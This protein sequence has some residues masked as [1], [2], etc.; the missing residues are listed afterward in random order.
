[1]FVAQRHGGVSSLAG[2]AK[3]LRSVDTDSIGYSRCQ[4]T[5]SCCRTIC[6]SWKFCVLT[7]ILTLVAL[8][9]DDFRQA[10]TSKDFDIV[11]NVITLFCILVFS[12]EVV[13]ASLG[14]EEYFLGF[15]FFLD[16]GATVTLLFDLTWVGDALFCSGLAGGALRASR[17]GRAGARASR[18]VRII[19][20]MRLVRLYRNYKTAM[21]I[22]RERRSRV[23]I[24]MENMLEP[25]ED[26][27]DD[28]ESEDQDEVGE[29]SQD[30]NAFRSWQLDASGRLGTASQSPADASTPRQETRVGKK[31]SDMTTRRVIVLVLVMLLVMPYFSPNSL[32]MEEFRSSGSYGSELVY[33]RWRSWCDLPGS[34][35]N[36]TQP[37]WC[38]DA[39]AINEMEGKVA[40]Q[41]ARLLLE[42]SLLAFTYSHHKGDFAWRLCWLGLR[43]DSLVESTGSSDH[44]AV[45]LSRLAALNQERMLG[46]GIAVAAGD[47]PGVWDLRFAG[48]NK[49]WRSNMQPL[50]AAVAERL[51]QPWP[52][53][54]LGFT[55]VWVQD[56]D[57][58]DDDNDASKTAASRGHCSIDELLRCSERIFIEP[59]TSTEEESRYLSL[60]FTFDIRA[61]KQLEAGL[62]ILQ[63]IFIC[64]TVGLGAMSFSKDANELLLNPIERMIAKMETIKD[65]PLEAMRLGDMEYRR[66][67][68]EHANHREQLAGM[69]KFWRLIYRYRYLKKT[70]EPMETAMLEKTIIKLG[71]LLALGFGEAGAEI[72]GQNMNGS[73][74]AGV[75][76]MV[77]GVSVNAILGFCNIRHFTDATEVLREK[78][79]MFVNQVGEIVHGCVD[80]YHGAPNKNIGSAFLIV[81]RLAALDDAESQR[82]LA[83]MALMAFAKIV[84]E[85]NKS[86]VLAVYREHP[87]L[88]Q[89]V[90]NFRVQMG[91]GL[92]CG[93]AIEG[94]IGSEFKIDASYLSPNVNVAT[95]LEAAAGQFSVW[96]L[97]S[98]FIVELYNSEMASKCRLIDHVTVKGSRIPL[99]LYTLDLDA[100][101][102]DVLPQ[103]PAVFVEDRTVKNRYKLRQLRE[104]EKSRK[105][106][107]DYWVPDAFEAD[108][109]IRLMR[110]KFSPEFFR[111]FAMAYRNYEA[112]E[113]R[114]ARDM[115]LTCHYAPKSDA[116]RCMIGSEADW[117]EDGPTVALLRFMGQFDYVPPLGWPGHRELADR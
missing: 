104:L 60:L 105:W 98:H 52:E 62:S 96:L 6:N 100:L 97:M 27:F 59:L 93:W 90:P 79:M 43:S 76:A 53:S 74:S 28:L 33:D 15:F 5:R 99:R 49:E 103:S 18:T 63:T 20:L 58:D 17:A 108:E 40:R 10:A 83:D 54:C 38:L 89:R 13:V 22:R 45:H 107:D 95:R 9:G 87:G 3:S 77:P 68:I 42:D 102:L 21:D 80:D 12:I 56:D 81:W 39:V 37:A 55:G 111:R 85:V 72:I 94:A 25:G 86:R 24:H 78:V 70:K 101:C 113:W 2:T 29:A 47:L 84:A 48:S 14:Q 73:S 117:P 7:T 65:N 91:F 26:G 109:D 30:L 112:G 114:A 69:S 51:A 110:R 16:L 34:S 4:R 19:R 88:L 64:F 61:A 71:G 8:F 35:G 32:G 115:L 106:Q 11:F 67:E 82:K 57:R 1:M 50:P 75:N 92:H 41:E 66:E 116:G 46:G 23:S 44:A 31:L 36:T